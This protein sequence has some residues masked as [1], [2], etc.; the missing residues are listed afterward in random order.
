MALRFAL[1]PGAGADPRVYGMTIAALEGL[2]HEAVAPELPLDD[3]AAT[4]SDHARAV[5]EALPED[6]VPLVVVGQSLGAFAAPLAAAWA[7]ASALILIAPMI[8][9]PGETAGEWGENVG[10]YEAIA[11]VRERFGPPSQWGEEAL[12]EVFLHDVPADV[13]EANRQY[14]GAPVPG[15]FSEPWPLDA[16]P[17]V[18]TRVIA[19]REDRLFPLELQ[20]RVTRERL[21]I[22]PDEIGGGHLPYLSRPEALARL[23][24]DLGES[25]DA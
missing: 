13:I 15:L 22:D 21:G 24:A 14:D 1:I 20:R 5:V 25:P 16:W 8:P 2:G 4:P 17:D 10:H 12:A 19:P 11:D 3:E 7:E 9:A 18:P 23:L 6:G